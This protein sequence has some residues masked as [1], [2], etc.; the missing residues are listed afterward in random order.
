MEAWDMFKRPPPFSHRMKLLFAPLPL[1]LL[2]PDGAEHGLCKSHLSQI[3][4]DHRE[5]RIQPEEF[6][7]VALDL[8]QADRSR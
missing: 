5:S 2:H 8:R 4:F 6:H 7:A 3:R 1:S